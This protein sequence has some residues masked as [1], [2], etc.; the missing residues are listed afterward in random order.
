MLWINIP[1]MHM[2]WII[3]EDSTLF[4]NAN[5]CWFAQKK[6]ANPM[7]VSSQ[8]N[9]GEHRITL[10]CYK[11]INVRFTIRSYQSPSSGDHE[12]CLTQ[13]P[14]NS[15]WNVSLSDLYWGWL[16]WETFEEPLFRTS[17]SDHFRFISGLK[18]VLPLLLLCFT[19]AQARFY[20]KKKAAESWHSMMKA[21]HQL[22]RHHV[23]TSSC[24][25]TLTSLIEGQECP[26]WSSFKRC[27]IYF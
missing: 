17:S 26:N 9:V 25:H 3:Q 18:S 24:E 19:G 2:F 8:I 13:I 5:I 15:Q 11:L 20:H 27:E 23:Q 4:S 6:K 7:S 1:K 21:W 16:F 22:Q 10:N 14:S 12:C